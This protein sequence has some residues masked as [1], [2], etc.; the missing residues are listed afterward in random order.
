MEWLDVVDE[1]NRPLGYSKP[2]PQ[3]H[4]DGDWHRTTHVYVLNGENELLCNLRQADKDLFPSVWDLSFGGHVSAGETYEETARRELEEEL[5]VTIRLEDLHFLYTMVVDGFDEGSG[6][7][8]REH[9]AVYLW[10]TDRPVNGFEFQEEEIAE[11]RYLPLSG[12]KDELTG[13]SRT[14]PLIPLPKMFLY[15]LNGIDAF[16]KTGSVSTPA[17]PR[18]HWRDL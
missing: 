7:T 2:K 18:F 13:R 6:L 12:L 8:D 14:L 17:Q 5:G 16:L 10:R 1:A 9:T 11:I 4:R 15:A 3:I